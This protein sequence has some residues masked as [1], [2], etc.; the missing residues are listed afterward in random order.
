ML[1][2][3]FQNPEN[4]PDFDAIVEQ[5]LTI[6]DE[7][8]NTHNPDVNDNGRKVNEYL[9]KFNSVEEG[10][11]FLQKFTDGTEA[12]EFAQTF[13][14]SF[15]CTSKFIKSFDTSKDAL[16]HL[17]TIKR[18]CDSRTNNSCG[19]NCKWIFDETTKTLFIRG[20]GKMKNY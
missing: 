2:L 12:N 6:I 18:E 14:G 11:I 5:C 1:T 16:E 13:N 20:S 8:P 10:K 19:A 15:D 7:L 9:K 4:R 3:F 17:E